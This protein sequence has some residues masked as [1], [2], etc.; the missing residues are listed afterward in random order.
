MKREIKKHICTGCIEEFPDT[1]IFVVRIL[2]KFEM[3]FSTFFCE[4]CVKGKNFPPAIKVE[5]EKRLKEPK[6]KKVTEPKVK[7][8][9]TPK[10]SKK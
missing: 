4:K 2:D 3:E 7:K 1:E 6:V 9:S 8:V 5:V 10:K